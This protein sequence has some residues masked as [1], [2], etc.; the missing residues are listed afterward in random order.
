MARIH[1]DFTYDPGATTIGTPLSDVLDHRRGVCQDFAHLAIACLRSHGIPARYVSGYLETR[2]LPGQDKLQG[3]DSSHAWFSAYDP[4]L[5]WLDYDPTN[6][7]RPNGRHILTAWGRDYSD[8]TP[9]K[10]VI[11]GGGPHHAKVA[12]DVIALE[13]GNDETGKD[14]NEK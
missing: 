11:Y 5:G 8:V 13:E 1:R 7:Q 12:V 6:N 2:P 9:L 3:A 14:K 10:G 4:I